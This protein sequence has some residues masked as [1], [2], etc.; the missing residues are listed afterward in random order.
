MGGKSDTDPLSLRES[1]NRTISSLLLKRGFEDCNGT[2]DLG[3]DLPSE[4]L[5]SNPVSAE[6]QC[7]LKSG[8]QLRLSIE[9]VEHTP[10][11]V[12][13]AHNVQISIHYNSKVLAGMD[14]Q[15]PNGTGQLPAKQKHFNQRSL[16]L[17]L[18][19][20]PHTPPFL[21]FIRNKT[22]KFQTHSVD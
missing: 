2:M 21:I 22:N 19:L 12:S 10:P 8:A 6:L 15:L 1:S 3:L 17:A 11:R 9:H 14:L 7:T 4:V 16:S 18:N 20:L 5:K 13:S